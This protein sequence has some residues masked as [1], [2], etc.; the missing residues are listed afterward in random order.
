VAMPP[1]KKRVWTETELTPART[2]AVGQLFDSLYALEPATDSPGKPAPKDVLLNKAA[3]EEWV[4]F[5]NEHNRQQQELG[6]PALAA[7]WS[8]LEAYAA[9][10]ALVIHCCRAAA[11]DGVQPLLLDAESLRA[12]V[13][14]ARWF[15]GEAARVYQEIATDP[16][17][18]AE[19][20]LVEL[21]SRLGGEITERQLW[22]SSRVFRSPGAA[23]AALES[24]VSEGLGKWVYPGPSAD[25]GCP[26]RRFRLTCSFI[27]GGDRTPD[28]DSARGGSVTSIL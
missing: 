16:G 26:A 2:T 9:R 12:G 28:I 15:G 21:I 27:P 18:R 13:T 5:F 19:E 14:L 17:E 4:S 23:T 25:G 11:K 10:F 8:K 3:R 20:E 24:L 7:V 1:M 22:R 6:D